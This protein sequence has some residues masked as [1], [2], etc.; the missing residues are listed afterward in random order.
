[1]ID[2]ILIGFAISVPALL[3]YQVIYSRFYKGRQ[4]PLGAV[5]IVFLFYL[6]FCVSS[7]ELGIWVSRKLFPQIHGNPKIVLNL[8]FLIAAVWTT[9]VL[10][11]PLL[12]GVRLL[13][14]ERIRPIQWIGRGRAKFLP[15]REER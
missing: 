14:G 2:R 4:V 12:N 3:A 11:Q 5:I 9:H 8:V 6:V 15:N 13:L 10:I 1:M 7:L